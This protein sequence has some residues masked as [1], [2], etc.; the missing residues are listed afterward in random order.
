MSIL[1]RLND[2]IVPYDSNNTS[3]VAWTDDGVYL[4]VGD[5]TFDELNLFKRSEHTL[6]LVDTQTL[7]G[8]GFVSDNGLDWD[9]TGTYLAVAASTSKLKMFK[10][11]G[12]SF[13][14]VSSQDTF[15]GDHP[16]WHADNVHVAGSGALFARTGDSLVWTDDYS[17]SYA[18][19]CMWIGAT[20]YLAQTTGFDGVNIW[21]R[22]G[23]QMSTNPISIPDPQDGIFYGIDI[24]PDLN[25]LI[26]GRIHAAT[27]NAPALYRLN[28]GV[29]TFVRFVE[30]MN[31]ASPY[32][33]RWDPSGTFMSWGWES[34]GSHLSIATWDPDSAT[35]ISTTAEDFGAN[36]DDNSWVSAGGETFLASTDAIS[37]PDSPNQAA[38]GWYKLNAGLTIL[39]VKCP[40]GTWRYVGNSDIPLKIKGPDGSWIAFGGGGG[41][42]LWVKA[43]DGTWVQATS[44]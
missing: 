5:T 34:L 17:V 40:D 13:A 26:C 20:D 39:Q 25:Y 38:F 35:F 24:H 19:D 12:D 9:S 4:A 21:V 16:K 2:A 33:F 7:V 43:P 8:G 44:I 29:I 18:A 11:T 23:D 42:P 27:Y 6:T 32:G 10:R 41:G 36:G 30:E 14:E 3:S 15:R 28:G 1:T 37:Y 31:F 22:A